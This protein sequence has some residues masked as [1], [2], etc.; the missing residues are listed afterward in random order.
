MQI[1]RYLRP[2][3]FR[4]YRESDFDACLAIWRANE[5]EA[6]PSGY[7]PLYTESL[8]QRESFILVGES[9]G[10]L[11][12]SGGIAYHGTRDCAILSFGLV[13][14]EHQRRGFGTTLLIARLALLDPLP[15]GCSVAMEVTPESF[16][17]FQR[18]GFEGYHIHTDELGNRFGHFSRIVRPPDIEQ[19]RVQLSRCGASLP[20]VYELPNPDVY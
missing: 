9:A 8:Q 15:H 14:P 18:F 2:L 17:F 1:E 7:E 4:A 10:E 13:A 11:V 16:T 12:C 3:Q 20:D 6:F 5:G 19:C